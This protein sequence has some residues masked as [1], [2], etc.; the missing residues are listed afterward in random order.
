MIPKRIVKSAVKRNLLKRHIR[1]AFRA[2]QHRLSPIDL[3]IGLRGNPFPVASADLRRDLDALF[4][5][6]APDKI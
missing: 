4:D 1:E 3:V 5:R 2:R 6:L